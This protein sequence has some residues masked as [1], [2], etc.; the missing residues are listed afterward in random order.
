MPGQRNPDGSKNDD[1]DSFLHQVR[2]GKNLLNLD[3][4]ARNQYIASPTNPIKVTKISTKNLARKQLNFPV[5]AQ[6]RN[7]VDTT[8][9]G[10][11]TQHYQPH[12]T[13]GADSK[14]VVEDENGIIG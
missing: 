12:K 5:A 1:I 6:G 14:E 11:Q 9:A 2:A 13:G 10:L 4:Y 3:T 7:Q 8:P